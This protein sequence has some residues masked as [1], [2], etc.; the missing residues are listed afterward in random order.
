MPDVTAEEPQLTDLTS[1]YRAICR[2]AQPEI[3]RL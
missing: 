2:R 3:V 1:S